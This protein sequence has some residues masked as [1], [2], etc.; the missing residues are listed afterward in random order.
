MLMV[1]EMKRREVE[2]KLSKQGCVVLSEDG[3]HTKWGCPCGEHT[4]AIP[5]HRE[6]S[7]GVIRNTIRDLECLPKGWLQ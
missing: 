5:R 4:A 3:I 1:K 2:R 7:P 6:I